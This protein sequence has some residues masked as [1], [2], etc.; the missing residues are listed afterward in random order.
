MKA[1]EVKPGM[2]IRQD[3]KL[4]V[5]TK[6]E[7]R[8]PGNLRAFHQI[9]MR[10]I[11]KGGYIERRYSSSDELDV[12]TL[13]RRPMEYLYSEPGGH[14]FMDNEDYEQITLSEDMIGDDKVFLTAN[15]PVV[16]HLHET[17]PVMID[18][19]SSIEVEVTDTPPG[20]KG[21]TATNQLKEA[22]RETGLK[23]KVPPF[24]SI[25]DKIRV[26]TADGSYQSRA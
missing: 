15:L 10:E 22:T 5:I 20:I 2:A 12:T 16:I 1:T 9:K 4:Y 8:T 26:S 18:L 19:P 14:V 23:T 3:G 24:I 13:D 25:G 11:E 7:H 21:A 17:N 6:V